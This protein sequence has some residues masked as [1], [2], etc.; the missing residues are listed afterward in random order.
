M[1][2][3]ERKARLWVHKTSSEVKQHW[4]KCKLRVFYATESHLSANWWLFIK[5]YSTYNWLLSIHK[6][7]Q[8]FFKC[9]SCETFSLFQ[10]I[11]NSMGE[12]QIHMCITIVHIQWIT[13]A[14]TRPDWAFDRENSV[15]SSSSCQPAL[16][17]VNNEMTS[18]LAGGSIER[19][20]R[21]RRCWDSLWSLWSLC[22]T[23]G[24]CP[25]WSPFSVFVTAPL[26]RPAGL[27]HSKSADLTFWM[28]VWMDFISYKWEDI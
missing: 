24:H 1:G 5:L 18:Q 19:R 27:L 9:P 8:S 3:N 22:V 23:A 4:N 14:T 17:Q 6:Q 13:R 15:L 11:T 20:S 12:I 21:L 28:T 26:I 10:H 25:P 16:W 2:T 7:P